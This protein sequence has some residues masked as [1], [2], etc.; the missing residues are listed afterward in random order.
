MT[1]EQIEILRATN[2]PQAVYPNIELQ[3]VVALLRELQAVYCGTEY[4]RAISYAIKHIDPTSKQETLNN[5]PS[6]FVIPNRYSKYNDCYK[7][8]KLFYSRDKNDE[9]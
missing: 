3:E 5:E 9:F 1:E 8:I 4:C 7:D 2:H 6:E